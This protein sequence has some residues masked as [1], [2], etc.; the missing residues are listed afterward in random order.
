MLEW[1]STPVPETANI[2]AFKQT[3]EF[4]NFSSM[5]ELDSLDLDSLEDHIVSSIRRIVRAIE[6]H[7]QD[8][9]AKVGLT[10]PQLSVLKAIPALSPATPTSVARHL[11]LSQSTVSGILDRLHSKKLVKQEVS[12]SDKRLRRYRLSPGGK[13]LLASAPPLLQE[14]FLRNLKGLEAWERT[15]LL[16]ALQRTA[17]LMDAADLEAQPFLTMGE[18]SLGD[19][20]DPQK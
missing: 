2:R 13:T 7:S 20:L 15:M 11:S 10:S 12:P 17:C 8:L 5:A 4:G 16:S 18:A 1:A 3:V 19:D 14:S 9:I 6:M